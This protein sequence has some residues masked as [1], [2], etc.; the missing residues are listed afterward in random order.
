MKIAS[1]GIGHSTITG[2]S[3]VNGP[4]ANCASYLSANITYLPNAT[5]GA[6]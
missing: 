6:H 3:N 5:A 1:D 2:S 4:Q